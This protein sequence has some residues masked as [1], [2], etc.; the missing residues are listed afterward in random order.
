MVCE[1]HMIHTI[2]MYGLAWPYSLTQSIIFDVPG[3]TSFVLGD[4]CVFAGVRFCRA[5]IVEL[6]KLF[7]ELV[8]HL[9]FLKCN[10][11]SSQ[12][13]HTYLPLAVSTS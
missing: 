1:D 6:M 2:A 9:C 13:H 12:G 10:T 11:V 3:N 8:V 7:S 5:F 4:I